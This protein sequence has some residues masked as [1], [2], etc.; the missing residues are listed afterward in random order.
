M[1]VLSVCLSVCLYVCLSV[2][3]P[4][5]A[6]RPVP[7]QRRPRQRQR[8][9]RWRPL[10]LPLRLR[11]PPG[12]PRCGPGRAPSRGPCR[13]VPRGSCAGHSGGSGGCGSA[14]GPPG[15]PRRR[16][17]R[18]LGRGLCRTA[19]RR[20]APSS[21][22]P[23]GRGPA[24]APPPGS[25]FAVSQAP[26]IF[27]VARGYVLA[28]LWRATLAWQPDPTS[29]RVFR[30]PGA[31]LALRGWPRLD[32][33]SS[34]GALAR[35]MPPRPNWADPPRAASRCGSPPGGPAPGAPWPPGALGARASCSPARR[36]GRSTRWARGA[37]PASRSL[38][39]AREGA[40]A[41]R[42]A[43][44]QGAGGPR[45]RWAAPLQVPAG[46]PAHR[47]RPGQ[48]PAWLGARPC[49]ARDPC[50]RRRPVL[51]PLVPR[52]GP[53]LVAGRPGRPGLLRGGPLG[54]RG[55]EV[56]PGAPGR[57][58][59][60][61]RG[62]SSGCPPLGLP[63]RSRPPGRLGPAMGPGP[64]AAGGPGRDGGGYPAHALQAPACRA[65]PP[66]AAAADGLLPLLPWSYSRFP[67][68]WGGF[69]T[70]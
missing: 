52:P 24:R 39:A 19:P 25:W 21:R 47:F 35:A 57:P 54:R 67:A 16:P 59:A 40:P 64:A 5:P 58:P 9:G 60:G 68:I 11:P 28:F 34:A 31:A 32:A 36:G 33:A 4:T 30:F 42:G 46:G 61:G 70:I 48:G 17:G 2:C 49:L 55:H 20:R 8:P 18:A 56:G 27:Q 62:A 12:A 63:G 51:R 41:S 69:P 23:H 26:W 43:R 6:T 13:T 53:E 3:L 14:C 10:R 38:R 44:A 7:P 29:G 65:I 37:E 45:P 66:A 15:G 22:T 1:S 50:L